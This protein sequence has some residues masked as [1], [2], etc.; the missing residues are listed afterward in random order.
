MSFIKEKWFFILNV[1]IF[2]GSLGLYF[3]G[4]AGQAEKKEK[5]INLID[6]A[7]KSLRSLA[8]KKPTPAW[9]VVLEKTQSSITEHKNHIYSKLGAAD[10]LIHR[11]YDISNPDMVTEKAPQLGSYLVYKSNFVKKWNALILEYAQIPKDTKVSRRAPSKNKRKG[12]AFP[13]GEFFP[14][15]FMFEDPAS[16]VISGLPGGVQ[17][18][19]VYQEEKI[20]IK[21]F[22]CAPST[23]S[24]LE[25]KWLRNNNVPGKEHEMLEAMKNYWITVELLRIFEVVGIDALLKVEISPPMQTQAYNIGQDLFWTYRQISAFVQIQIG[26]TEKLW[27]EVHAS[28]YLFRA[29]G[30]DLS[31]I[32][33]LPQGVKSDAPHVSFDKNPQRQNLSVKLWHFDYIQEGEQL[34]AKVQSQPTR[35]RSRG[36]RSR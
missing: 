30:F 24:A 18:N 9:N 4:V 15:E 10:N 3:T 7:T 6:R 36:R 27:E 19:V 1:L 12:G 14:E 17:A 26:K 8:Y 23:I 28:P 35:G 34:V 25:P 31:N 2:A 29:V 16:A 5:E 32:I 11:Y 13:S 33:D 22:K 21:H 20:E